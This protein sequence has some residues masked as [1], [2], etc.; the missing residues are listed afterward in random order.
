LLR[1]SVGGDARL[2]KQ[3]QSLAMQD[4]AI[5][6]ERV[7]LTGRR[8]RLEPLTLAHAIDLSR[9]CVH[10]EIWRYLR[11][12]LRTTSDVESWIAIALEEQKMGFEVPFAIID[13]KSGNA[14]GSTRYFT[15]AAKDRGLEIGSTWFTPS[16]WRTAINSEAKYLLLAHAF[17]TLGCIRVQFITDSRNERSRRAIERLGATLEGTIRHHMIMRHGH[18]RDSLLF[19]ILDSEWPNH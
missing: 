3:T 10:A 12:E 9:I 5:A 2:S 14:V 6:I 8:V 18:L 4:T 15:I 11:A 19:S 17:E 7:V 16:V 1:Q 13:L